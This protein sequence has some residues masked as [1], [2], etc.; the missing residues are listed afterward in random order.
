M[1]FGRGYLAAVVVELE[2]VEVDRPGNRLASD[3]LG[4]GSGVVM[5]YLAAL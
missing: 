5:P 1:G 2:W 3:P 4:V